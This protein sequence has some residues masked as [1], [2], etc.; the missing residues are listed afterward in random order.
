MTSSYYI[1]P[2]SYVVL[3]YT[4]RF[5]FFKIVARPQRGRGSHFQNHKTTLYCIESRDDPYSSAAVSTPED[6][7]AR[8]I[9]RPYKR[10]DTNSICTWEFNTLREAE[11]A[12]VLLVL[13][14]S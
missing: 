2:K 3:K 4:T 11:K 9:G 8:L 10:H 5:K 7:V 13:K 6:D 1:V 14:Y 12:W